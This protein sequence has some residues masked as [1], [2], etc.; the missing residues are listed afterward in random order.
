MATTTMKD[1]E[2]AV[3]VI[4]FVSGIVL[5]TVSHISYGYVLS[6]LWGWFIAPFGLPPISA[7]HAI[8]LCAVF[9]VTRGPTI[10]HKGHKPDWAALVGNVLIG[11]WVIL[12]VGYIAHNFMVSP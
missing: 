12:L 7:A 1:D 6:V 3:G 5:A 10:T 11:P 9:S 8:G 4:T 2:I